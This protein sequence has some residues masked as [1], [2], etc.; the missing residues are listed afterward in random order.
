V[1]FVRAV[2]LVPERAGAGDA[3]PWSLPVVRGLERLE[4][5]PESP[6]SMRRMADLLAERSQFVIAT[7][8]PILMAFPRR[9]ARAL[10]V[11]HRGALARS[12]HERQERVVVT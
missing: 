11:E 5:D 7:H 1:S 10:A 2:E 12:V 4:L 3:Y 6:S 8:S 9:L